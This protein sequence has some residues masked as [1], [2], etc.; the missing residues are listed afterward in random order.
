MGCQEQ[1]FVSQAFESNYIAPLGPQVDAF[2]KEFCELSG[3]SHAVALS[4]GT[5]AMH[6]ALKLL[7]VKPGDEILASTLTFIGSVSPVTFEGATPVFIDCDHTSWNMDPDLL[8]AELARCAKK[9]KLPA[10]VVPTDLYGQCANYDRIYDICRPYAVPVIVDS[11]EALGAKYFSQKHGEQ[12]AGA[13]AKA[14]VFSFNGNKIITTSG[15]GMLTS[16]DQKFIEHARFL[17]Q[18]AR[19]P[20]PHYE[21]TEIGYNYRMSNILAAIGRGQLQALEA[22]V[23]RK[24]EIFEYYRKALAD[25]PGMEF[26]PEAAYGRCNRWLTVLLITPDLF[27]ADRETVRLTLEAE[28]IESRPVWKPMHMQPVFQIDGDRRTASVKKRYPARVVGGAVSEDLFDRGLCLPSGTAM[29]ASD[30]ERVVT[31]IRKCCRTI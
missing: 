15:G 26:M 25:L 30:L 5:A 20:F 10:A 6:L 19:D 1:H 27:G 9:G 8:A 11:A 3:A 4:S 21:H 18:Q 14:A 17:S 22:R 7:G 29:D 16:D 13:G 12:H 23:L 24:R 31:A 2:E 28:N